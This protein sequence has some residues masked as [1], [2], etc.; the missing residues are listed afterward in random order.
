[1]I[2]ANHADPK[3][4][5]GKIS[6]EMEIVSRSPE[7]WSEEIIGASPYNEH[8]GGVDTEVWCVVCNDVEPIFREKTVQSE[9]C[10]CN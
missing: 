7:K 8:T 4:G 1:M 5:K 6:K 10:K 2:G 3:V 9:G